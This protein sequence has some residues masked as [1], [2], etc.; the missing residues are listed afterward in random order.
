[1]KQTIK[2]NLAELGFER[3][4]YKSSA[5]PSIQPYDHN[6][7]A[8]KRQGRDLKP[9]LQIQPACCIDEIG[10]DPRLRGMHGYGF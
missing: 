7:R 9:H 2:E 10:C 1:M 4:G 6:D 3:M 5:L 8:V